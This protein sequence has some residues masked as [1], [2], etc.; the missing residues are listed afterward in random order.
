MALPLI[1]PGKYFFYPI[2]NIAA[3]DLTRDIPPDV[4]ANILL[5]P[6]GDPRNIL[7]TVSCQADSS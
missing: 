2:G 3:V 7:Y 5:L 4:P 1:W 6:V